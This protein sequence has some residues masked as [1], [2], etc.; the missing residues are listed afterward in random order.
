MK[1]RR[2]IRKQRS[3]K[4]IALLI[5]IFVVMLIGVMAIALIISSGTETALAG[6]YRSSTNV[7]YA[8][9]AGLEEVRSRLRNN[10]PNS[11]QSTAPN[12]FLPA[13]GSCTPSYVINQLPG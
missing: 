3:E 4:G 1:A 9:V 8:A 12:N 7:Y 6:N 5:A 13:P 11:F 10:T 2:P